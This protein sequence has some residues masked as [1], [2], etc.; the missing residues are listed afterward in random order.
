MKKAAVISLILLSAIVFLSL[1][2]G[3]KNESTQQ[4]ISEN[5]SQATEYSP[6]FLP[7][8]FLPLHKPQME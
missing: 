5:D 6:S 7:Q 4:L 2:S 3:N 1:Y 8:N